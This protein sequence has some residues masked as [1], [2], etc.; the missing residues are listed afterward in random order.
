MVRREALGLSLD[1]SERCVSSTS[2]VT[3]PEG[4]RSTCMS[5]EEGQ[6]CLYPVIQRRPVWS[7]YTLRHKLPKKKQSRIVSK[8]YENFYGS[9][10]DPIHPG[11]L[12]FLPICLFWVNTQGIDP[13]RSTR[14]ILCCPF[15][16]SVQ[17]VLNLK[18]AIV[19]EDIMWYAWQSPIVK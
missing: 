16:E 8:P 15:P 11:D 9:V 1:S 19:Q 2:L 14:Q 10:V 4:S 17:I 5:P 3:Q 6:A 18:K 13:Q 12:D 7:C